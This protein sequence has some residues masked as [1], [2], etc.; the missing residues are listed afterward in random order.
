MSKYYEKRKF[1]NL[2]KRLKII[3]NKLNVNN[4]CMNLHCSDYNNNTNQLMMVYICQKCQR[5][6]NGIYSI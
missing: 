6:I 4:R 1:N 2:D 3:E 5:S